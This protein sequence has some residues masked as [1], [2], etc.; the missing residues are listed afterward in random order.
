LIRIIDRTLSCLDGL[1]PPDTSALSRF[2]SLLTELDPGAIELSETMYRLLSPLPAY[3]SYVLRLS[4]AAD[5]AKYP[6]IADF[7]C[8][9]DGSTGNDCQK[10]RLVGLSGAIL[11]DYQQTFKR[12]KHGSVEFCPTNRLYCAAALAAEWA[13]SGAAGA[14]GG[15]V[16]AFGGLGGFAATEELIM[17]L[18]INNL[19]CTDKNYDF[20]PEMARVFEQIAKKNIAPNKPIIG[21]RIFH[22]ESGIHVDG[23]LKQPVCYEPFPPEIVGQTRKIVLG[24]QSGI[25]SVRSKLSE[26]KLRCDEEMLPIILAGVKAKAVEKRGAVTD[27][28]FS[29]V[30]KSVHGDTAMFINGVSSTVMPDLIRHPHESQVICFAKINKIAG[31]ARNDGGSNKIAGQARNDGGSNIN[32]LNERLHKIIDCLPRRYLV[33]STLRDGEQTPGIFFS[34]NQKSEIAA[35]LDSFGVHQIEAGVPAASKEEKTAIA[36]IIKKRKNAVISV[37]ARLVPSDIRHAIDVRPDL[38]H[39]CVPVSQTQIHEKLRTDKESVIN[40]LRECLQIAEKSG[41][42]LSVGFE[43]AFRA[44]I[45]FMLSI[46]KILTDSGVTRIRL[47]DTVGVA[48]PS[49]CRALIKNISVELN[50]KAELGIHAHNDLG[51]AVANTIEAAK[52]GCLYA[53]VTIGGIGERAGN[54][55]FAELVQASSSIF[56]WGVTA[57]AARELQLDFKAFLGFV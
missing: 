24:R 48:S 50:G 56:D 34:P 35:L 39:I 19:I 22:V 47:S 53:D 13:M 26:L 42:P 18:R 17:I 40:R 8:P 4:K 1:P 36:D 6:D 16:T 11:G 49:Q 20:L 25:A 43:D 33:D 5:A 28:E 3:P 2:L 45:D 12:L 38:I 51:M 15:V 41:I 52:S 54:C 21:K 37:W 27:R 57:E 32:G 30:V 9:K 46:S 7:V 31:Q 44:D 29:D 55:G 14:D 23:I 10:L